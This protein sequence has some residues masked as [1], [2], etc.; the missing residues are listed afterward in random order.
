MFKNFKMKN[1]KLF[2]QESLLIVGDYLIIKISPPINDFTLSFW[3]KISYDSV[4]SNI[5]DQ[6]FSLT[7]PVNL[8]FF[9]NIKIFYRQ[10]EIK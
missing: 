2:L 9:L 1:N 4:N 5:S 10:I 7:W 6:F 8:L 3:M